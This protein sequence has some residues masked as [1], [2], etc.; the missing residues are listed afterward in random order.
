MTE[1]CRVKVKVVHG[2]TLKSVTFEN[3][4]GRALARVTPDC[5]NWIVPDIK[6]EEKDAILKLMF[7]IRDIVA[8][9]IANG[10]VELIVRVPV[11][12]DPT[13]ERF[14]NVVSQL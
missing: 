1:A 11:E 13:L 12:Y 2:G 6:A 10:G 14:R 4:D 7:N 3:Q 8:P 9:A 5:N